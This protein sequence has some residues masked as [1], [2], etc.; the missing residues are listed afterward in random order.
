MNQIEKSHFFF[1][2]LEYND[3]STTDDVDKRIDTLIIQRF[4]HQLIIN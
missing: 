2:P 3:W 4:S 1:S